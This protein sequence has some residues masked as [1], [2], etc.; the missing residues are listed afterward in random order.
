MFNVSVLTMFYACMYFV[1][2]NSEEFYK[3]ESSHLETTPK[4][5]EDIFKMLSVRKRVFDIIP[6]KKPKVQIRNKFQKSAGEK[7]RR[8]NVV[9][10]HGRV[11]L[12]KMFMR[13]MKKN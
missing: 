12:K 10:K 8:K 2:S 7:T 5:I 6:S 11:L 13:Q 1:H 4:Y 3:M 9:E